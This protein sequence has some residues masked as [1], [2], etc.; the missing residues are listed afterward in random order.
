[1]NWRQSLAAL[2][3]VAALC[4]LEAGAG[5]NTKNGNFYISYFDIVAGPLEVGRA[6]NSKSTFRG[7]FGY[8]WGTPY[9]S[10]LIVGPSGTPV[11]FQNGGGAT[12]YFQPDV[13][14]SSYA[15]TAAAAIKTMLPLLVTERGANRAA[16]DS[17]DHQRL[18]GQVQQQL[19]DEEYRNRAWLRLLDSGKVR[20][21]DV[22]Q[23]AT[24]RY[25]CS[26]SFKSQQLTRTP[27]GYLYVSG[28]QRQ[29][30]SASGQLLSILEGSGPAIL[31]T[32]YDSGKDQG[33]I[34]SLSG[35]GNTVNVTLD[36]AG[37]V[38]QLLH[39]QSSKTARYVYDHDNLVRSD[40]AGGNVFR[41]G[42]DARHNMT[43]ITYV[44][45]S[46]LTIEYDANSAAVKEVQRNGATTW[47]QYGALPGDPVLNYY[48]SIKHA[49]SA[50]PSA[51][52]SYERREYH[53]RRTPKGGLALEQQASEADNISRR[54]RYN[55]LGVLKRLVESSHL[56]DSAGT[57]TDYEFDSAGRVK[58]TQSRGWRRTYTYADDDATRVLQLQTVYSLS[59][60]HI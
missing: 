30:Y 57:I 59:L 60:I 10:R 6:Y 45:D 33:R 39:V 2:A 38:T 41:F 18:Q 9:E 31:I 25:T 49:A 5:I 34:R 23:G 42:Y 47:Y 58:T 52:V 17:A 7:M 27:Q 32:R 16:L 29:T 22:P 40:D 20:P 43:S 21:L 3:W 13:A 4:P 28:T 37:H 14:N 1:M 55:E 36:A 54:Y 46:K 35:G 24:F 51:D 56:S 44:D 53:F 15:A 50:L 12:S 26:C 11:I 19:Q 48:T 8:G